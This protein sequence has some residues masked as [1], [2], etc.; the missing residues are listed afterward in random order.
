MEIASSSRMPRTTLRAT[1]SKRRMR[2]YSIIYSVIRPSMYNTRS[3]G[4]IIIADL[5]PTVVSLLP[6]TLSPVTSY[7]HPHSPTVPC[8]FPAIGSPLGPSHYRVSPKAPRSFFWLPSTSL[9]LF[10]ESSTVACL[11]SQSAL[12]L[13]HIPVGSQYIRA[14]NGLAGCQESYLRGRAAV[15]KARGQGLRVWHRGGKLRSPVDAL[16][17][18][19]TFFA[20]N[21]SA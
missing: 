14:H 11:V 20:L 4:P 12:P 19:N 21:S 15:L 2:S 5:L 9:C 18:T 8:E 16:F 1:D 7:C 17:L 6:P 10:A 13:S 3:W